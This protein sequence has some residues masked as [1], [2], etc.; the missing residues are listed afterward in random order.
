MQ[1]V[2][3]IHNTG[4]VRLRSVT[5]VPTLFRGDLASTVSGLTPY[6]CT[7]GWNDTLPTSLNV[8][9]SM[10]CTANYT[11]VDVTYIEAG[12]LNFTAQVQATGLAPDV[13]ALPEVQMLR[14]VNA[15]MVELTLNA[16]ACAAPSALSKWQP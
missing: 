9:S 12:D 4:N 2:V 16:S 14:V 7:G 10:T 1:H 13:T 11:F 3:V 6:S 8:S 15:P 5:I